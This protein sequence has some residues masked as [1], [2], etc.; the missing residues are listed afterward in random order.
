MTR[1]THLPHIDIIVLWKTCWVAGSERSR[2][3]DRKIWEAKHS[4]NWKYLN[5]HKLNECLANKYIILHS[6]IH[7]VGMGKLL[8][9]TRW[10]NISWMWL[11]SQRENCFVL[12]QW[13]SLLHAEIKAKAIKQ[14]NSSPVPPQFWIEET[15][16]T[17]T[18][19]HYSSAWI[20]HSFDG[21]KIG[22][23]KRI[24]TRN[25]S[26][27]TPILATYLLWKTFFCTERC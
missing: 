5:T 25:A 3:I 12:C 15:F 23:L 8:S 9:L 24:W 22:C 19:R 13:D 17:L 16:L 4:G 10:P 7:T 1:F 20:T 2:S 21:E 27:W 11:P 6:C 26:G 14:A 18:P